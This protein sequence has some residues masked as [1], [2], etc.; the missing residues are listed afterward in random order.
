MHTLA[1][2]ETQVRRRIKFVHTDCTCESRIVKAFAARLPFLK[3]A[4][5]RI[6]SVRG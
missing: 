1:I 6:Q 3:L 4:L 5:M 2:S